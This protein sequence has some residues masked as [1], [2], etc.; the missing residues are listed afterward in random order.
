MYYT[1]LYRSLILEILNLTCTVADRMMVS[2]GDLGERVGA[3]SGELG[4]RGG[5]TQ[6]HDAYVL[7]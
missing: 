1:R 7:C 6:R 5:V 2:H 4:A 3:P